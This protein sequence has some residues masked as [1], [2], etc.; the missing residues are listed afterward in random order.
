MSGDTFHTIEA[1][2]TIKSLEQR[3]YFENKNDISTPQ[4]TTES[5]HFA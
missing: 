4:V 5:E 2:Q 3:T 1:E